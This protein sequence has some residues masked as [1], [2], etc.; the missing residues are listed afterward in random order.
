MRYRCADVDVVVTATGTDQHLDLQAQIQPHTAVALEFALPARLR[1]DPKQLVRLVCPADGNQSVGTAFRGPFFEPQDEESPS[2]WTSKQA[3]PQGYRLLYGGP[4]VYRPDAD[5]PVV[6]RVT[7]QGKA[8]LTP[9]SPRDWP[10]QRRP[11]TGRRKPVRP[12]WS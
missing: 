12:I 4:L 11:S 6:L 5:P 9:K 3:G 7:E 10:P 8:W 2:G 1:F